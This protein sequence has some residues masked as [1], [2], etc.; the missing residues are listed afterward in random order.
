MKRWLLLLLLGA[1]MWQCLLVSTRGQTSTKSHV[2]YAVEMEGDSRAARALAKQHGLQFISKI[3]NMEGHYT[4][5]DTVATRSRQMV[6]N[7][8]SMVPEVKWVKHQR[9]HYRDK[10]ATIS[11]PDDRT[12]H[13]LVQRQDVIPREI[14]NVINSEEGL[15]DPLLF[16]DPYWPMQWELYNQGQFGSPKRFDL[17]IM[18]VWKRNITGKG[19]VVTIIDDGQPIK[20]L[21][22]QD[23]LGLLHYMPPV[24]HKF[25]WDLPVDGNNCSQ[26]FHPDDVPSD[27]EECSCDDEF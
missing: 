11:R 27:S 5:K 10:R 4:F 21:K 19:V 12:R 14:Y 1:S 3:G 17:N 2:F 6:E 25:Y 24:Y 16:N 18:P 15:K 7:R 9:A 20:A 26:E 22:K 13:E 23:L 8:L